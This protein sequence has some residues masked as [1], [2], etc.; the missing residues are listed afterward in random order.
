MERLSRFVSSSSSSPWISLINR[1]TRVP[2]PTSCVLHAD[3]VHKSSRHN[4]MA[5]KV[6]GSCPIRI[7]HM[8]HYAQLEE[9]RWSGWRHI[10]YR[11][12]KERSN[13]MVLIARAHDRCRHNPSGI[14]VKGYGHIVDTD[15]EIYYADHIVVSPAKTNPCRLP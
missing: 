9:M 4:E 8:S 6:R 14:R 5:G 7:P 12:V 3:D 13:V 11:D 1:V 15:G 10:G 2:S